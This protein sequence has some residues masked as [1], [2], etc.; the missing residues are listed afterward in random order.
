[1]GCGVWGG[2]E[3][4]YFEQR[5]CTDNVDNLDCACDKNLLSL[6]NLRLQQFNVQLLHR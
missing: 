6:Y 2:E 1:M 5:P 4:H 3:R